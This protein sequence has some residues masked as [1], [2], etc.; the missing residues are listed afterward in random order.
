[1]KKIFPAFLLFLLLLTFSFYGTYASSKTRLPLNPNSRITVFLDTERWFDDDFVRQEITIVNYVRDREQADVH[2]IVTRHDAGTAGTNYA[3]SFIGNRSFIGKNHEFTYWAPSTNSSDD[4]RRGYTNIL[5]IGLVPY[6]ASTSE[7]ERI[8]VDFLM[9]QEDLSEIAKASFETDPWKS[10][11]FELYG[12]GNFEKEEKLSHFSFRTG[13]FADRIT[14]EWK[15][16]IRPY[17][18]FNNSTYITTEGDIVNST[19]R[20]GYSAY[21]IKSLNNHWSMGVFSSGLSSTFHNMDLSLDLVPA[22]EWSLFPYDEATRR[23]VVLAYRMGYGHNDYMETTI[24]SKNEEWV[25]TQS[26]EASARFQQPWGNVRAGLTGS[27]YF[28][29]FSKNRVQVYTSLNLRIFQGFSLNLYG[30]YEIIND[31]IAIPAGDLSLEEILLARSQ[32]ATSYSISGSIGL[33][34]TFGSRYSA[35]Y[36]PRL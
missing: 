8:H 28:N 20:H 29:D 4:T 34:Y 24:F 9:D 10:W 13:F 3:I 12:G 21:V 23:S 35:A 1:M 7:I 25:W 26:L 33:S 6:L 11:V 30:N 2:I 36:N 19:H 15:I 17:F 14:A 27:N 31:L 22:I 16:R 18:N 5:K 32:Q